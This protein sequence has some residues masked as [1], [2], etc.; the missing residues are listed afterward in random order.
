MPYAKNL[1]AAAIPQVENIVHAVKR[2]LHRNK[3]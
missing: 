1:E 3:N 2:T